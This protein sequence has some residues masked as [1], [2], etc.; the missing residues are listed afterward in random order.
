MLCRYCFI[1]GLSESV[2]K[3]CMSHNIKK[4]TKGVCYTCNKRTT[5]ST[6]N[7][8]NQD[9]T[10]SERSEILIFFKDHGISPFLNTSHFRFILFELPRF[11]QLCFFKLYSFYISSLVLS[12]SSKK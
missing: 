6:F 8:T 12:S 4:G 7:L 11:R 2:V 10:R 1:P 5:D 3:C 9:H